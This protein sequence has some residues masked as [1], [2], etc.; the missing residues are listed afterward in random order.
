[1]AFIAP[2]IESAGGITFSGF[3]DCWLRTRGIHAELGWARGREVD[4]EILL[5]N[6]PAPIE[7]VVDPEIRGE[8]VVGRGGDD[9]I[10][11][12]VGGFQAKNSNRLDADVLVGGGAGDASVGSIGDG[13]GEDVGGAAAF[14][15][16]VDERDFDLLEGAVEVET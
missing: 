3:F 10:F 4:L 14:V 2:V 11:Q 7:G 6:D 8:W 16:D 12:N 1:M 5:R 13:A 9:A 15:G